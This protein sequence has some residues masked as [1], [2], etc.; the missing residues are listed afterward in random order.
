MARSSI[1]PLRS[2]S[3]QRHHRAA[4][5]ERPPGGVGGHLAVAP[6]PRASSLRRER[7]KNQSVRLNYARRCELNISLLQKECISTYMFRAGA[8]RSYIVATRCIC[9]CWRGF[10]GGCEQLSCASQGFDHD[11]GFRSQPLC[12]PLVF[13]LRSH[14]W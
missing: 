1:L 12:S 9:Q 3:E 2:L 10:S 5:E 7:E 14:F 11:G 6:S 4:G 13:I 8:A